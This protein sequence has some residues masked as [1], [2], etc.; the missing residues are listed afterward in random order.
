MDDIRVVVCFV[1]M[2]CSQ[3][4][5]VHPGTETPRMRVHNLPVGDIE[6]LGVGI[7]AGS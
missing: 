5:V 6:A 7:V 4:F 2:G 3:N 1:G